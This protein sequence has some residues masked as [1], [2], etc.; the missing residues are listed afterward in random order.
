M[1]AS[2]NNLLGTMSY[3][4]FPVLNTLELGQIAGLTEIEVVSVR[5]V[6]S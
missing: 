2:F 6:T 3:T 5:M 1:N 4:S